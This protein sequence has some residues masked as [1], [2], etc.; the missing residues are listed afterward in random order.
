LYW[1]STDKAIFNK[2]EKLLKDIQRDP[3]NGIGKLE[4]LKYSH[5]GRWSRRID[6]EHRLIY[7]VS[8]NTICIYGCREHY[9]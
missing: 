9:K 2:I 1:K 7:S 3:F 8:G 4:P 5:A 6:E